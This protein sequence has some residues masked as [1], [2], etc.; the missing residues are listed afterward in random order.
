M[1][2]RKVFE[3]DAARYCS[4]DV[5]HLVRRLGG[6]FERQRDGWVIRRCVGQLKLPS[7]DSLVIASKKAPS[8]AILAW[9]AYADP[10][11]RS[12]QNFGRLAASA[13]ISELT[14]IIA[15]L[16]LDEV[17]QVASRNGLVR[18]YQRVH[19]SSST[20]RGAIDFSKLVRQGGNLSRIPCVVWE[21]LS[22]TPLN[23]ILAKAIDSLRRVPGILASC[24]PQLGQVRAMFDGVRHGVD[25]ALLDGKKA[26]SRS[27]APFEGALALAR[28]I[29]RSTGILQGQ[30]E[31]GLAFL[32][33]L[34]ELFERAV[35]TAFKEN[36]LSSA[37]KVPVRYRV[38]ASFES[39]RRQSMEMDV[40]VQ[41]FDGRPL[42]VDAKYKKQ[43]SSGNLQ[44]MV[45]YCFLT[46]AHRAVLVF[47]QG[48]LTSENAYYFDG[49]SGDRIRVDVA[50]LRTDSNNL[51]DWRRAGAELVLDCGEEDEFKQTAL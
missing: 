35:A 27:Q 4:Q 13:E 51:R 46:G 25:P 18:S 28:L 40:F 30:E 23:R 33:N 19:L 2:R 37:A 11:L 10:T 48:N 14:A 29:L 32:I 15:K 21:R 44:Q 47:P 20:V 16:F 43:V 24:G 12:L 8:A 42:V 3:G 34:E 9:A 36:N 17:L 39:S 38:G 31:L 22:D 1:T 50:E 7:G 6:S 41:D 5:E 26:L 45:T 49:P